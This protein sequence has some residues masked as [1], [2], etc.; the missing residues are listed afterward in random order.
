MKLVI[1][2]M[3]SFLVAALA[4]LLVIAAISDTLIPELS[5]YIS[6]TFPAEKNLEFISTVAADPDSDHSE[7]ADGETFESKDYTYTYVAS[8]GGWSVSVKDKS[9]A[10]YA[11]LYETVYNRPVVSLKET[12]KDCSDLTQAPAIPKTVQNVTS[13]FEGCASLTGTIFVYSNPSQ[14]TNCFAGTTKSITLNGTGSSL[15][16]LAAT[17]SSGN[18]VV[19]E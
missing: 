12:F 5:Q 7:P 3:G 4:V 15:S 14:Y 2:A 8:S 9:K 18:V 16:E 6:K 13:A 10:E 19:K 17:S 1:R 11:L